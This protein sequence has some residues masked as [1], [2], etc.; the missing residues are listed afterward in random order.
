MRHSYTAA[1]AGLMLSAVTLASPAF[2]AIQYRESAYSCPQTD[3]TQSLAS[4]PERADGAQE[5][6]DYRCC[7]QRQPDQPLNGYNADCPV[8]YVRLR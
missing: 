5:K 3:P 6:Y 8:G 4:V 1:F 2:A 7:V